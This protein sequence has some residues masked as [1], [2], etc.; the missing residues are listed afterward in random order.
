MNLK[1]SIENAEYLKRSPWL[2]QWTMDYIKGVIAANEVLCID[3]MWDRYV[4]DAR[5][6][7]ESGDLAAP[8][9]SEQKMA[10]PGI[11]DSYGWLWTH[12]GS[13]GPLNMEEMLDEVLLVE[14]GFV[15]PVV[16]LMPDNT[17]APQEFQL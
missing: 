12:F 3:D 5:A 9:L 6:A 7:I 14:G 10:M 16:Y 13:D 17:D 1:A 4:A 15:K 11:M 8:E 2:R